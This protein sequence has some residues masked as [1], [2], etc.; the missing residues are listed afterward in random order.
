MKPHRTTPQAL[1]RG[2]VLVRLGPKSA[3]VTPDSRLHQE[4]PTNAVEIG[5]KINAMSIPLTSGRWLP[6]FR[7]ARRKF[8]IHRSIHLM[9]GPRGQ[10]WAGTV[11]KIDEM[12]PGQN[13]PQSSGFETGRPHLSVHILHL[14]VDLHAFQNVRHHVFILWQAGNGSTHITASKSAC[15]NAT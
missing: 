11:T 3:T 4:K 13:K 8:E 15:N 5:S 2:Y 6:V 14:A 9:R 12:D 7:G 1:T 10:A